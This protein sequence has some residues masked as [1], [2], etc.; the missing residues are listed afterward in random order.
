MRLSRLV[1]LYLILVL[2]LAAVGGV[3][4]G[5]YRYE[6]QLIERK[7]EL[8]A[9]ITELRAGAAQVRGPLAVGAWAREQGMVPSP[10]IELVRH[11]A[12][13]PAPQT[14]PLPTG[15]EVRTVWR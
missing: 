13:Y 8:Y 2:A 9:H 7:S 15:V 1:P 11:V 12:P 5:R 6:A 10:E 3:N 4:Q 14:T